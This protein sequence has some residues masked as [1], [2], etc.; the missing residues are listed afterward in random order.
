VKILKENV[1]KIG[2]KFVESVMEAVREKVKQEAIRLIVREAALKIAKYLGMMKKE[3]SVHKEMGVV[4]REKIDETDKVDIF[5]IFRPPEWIEIR[6]LL[7]SSSEI[8]REILKECNVLEMLMMLSNDFAEL[9]FC[10]DREGN[11]FAKQNILVGAL[12]F[13]VFKEEYDA[14]YVSAVI[15]R[16]DVLPKIRKCIKDYEEIKDAYSGII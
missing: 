5:V 8:S 9:S 11:I 6:S 14:V 2:E 3:Y 15:F 4:V 13:D 12:T 1:Q 10:I 16:K 7:A